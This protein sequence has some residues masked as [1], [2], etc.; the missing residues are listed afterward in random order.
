MILTERG[1]MG[2]TLSKLSFSR[3]STA[4]YYSTMYYCGFSNISHA[5]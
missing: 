1:G 4:V 5:A 3:F 2:R